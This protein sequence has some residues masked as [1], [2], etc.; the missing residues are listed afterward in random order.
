MKKEKISR[1]GSRIATVCAYVG[2]SALFSL[3]GIAVAMH[4]DSETLTVYM[5]LFSTVAVW[6][7]WRSVP[8]RKI[9]QKFFA[10]V[11][12]KKVREK[13]NEVKRKTA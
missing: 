1:A 9:G 2:F 8:L 3:S 4:W 10:P 12:S 11:K 5:L 7:L 13:E 6:G